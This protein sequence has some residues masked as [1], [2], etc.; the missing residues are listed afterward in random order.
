MFKSVM[1]LLAVLFFQVASSAETMNCLAFMMKATSQMEKQEK[2]M[3]GERLALRPDSDGILEAQMTHQNMEFFASAYKDERSD[4]YEL[5]YGMKDVKSGKRELMDSVLL[6]GTGP[7]KQNGWEGPEGTLNYE[8]IRS[9][10]QP[11]PMVGYFTHSAFVKLSPLGLK[12]SGLQN[13]A[14]YNELIQKAVRSGVLKEGEVIGAGFML[15]CFA[16]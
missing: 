16:Q 15:N 7:S 13:L 12:S 2:S 8:F 11:A 4:V 3:Y 1:S 14:Q 6:L 5:S 9:S 10:L